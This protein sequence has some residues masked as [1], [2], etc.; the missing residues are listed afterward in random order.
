MASFLPNFIYFLQLALATILGIILGIERLIAKRP[1]GP[2]TYGLVSLGAC[3]ATIISLQVAP[4]YGNAPGLNPLQIV[5]NVILGIGF[6]GTGLIFLQDTHINGLTTAAGVWVSA[7]I[8]IAV[9]F[10]FYSLATFATLI[11]LFLF[12]IFWRVEHGIVTREEKRQENK[13]Q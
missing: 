3:L 7:I 1:A 12:T 6:L 4:L 8:G 11:T 5:A 2:R 10:G 9:G 13:V